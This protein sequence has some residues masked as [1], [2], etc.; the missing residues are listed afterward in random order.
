MSSL[1][2]ELWCEVLKNTYIYG[3]SIHNFSLSCRAFRAIALPHLFS[4][5]RFTPYDLRR[6][7]HI[8]IIRS[9][10][11]VERSMDRLGFWCSPAIAPLARVCHLRSGDFYDDGEST[12]DDPAFFQHLPLLIVLQELHLD[13][14]LLSQARVDAICRFSTGMLANLAISCCYLASGEPAAS[15]ELVLN[16]SA[17]RLEAPSDEFWPL[18][19]A[20]TPSSA[21]P[22]LCFRAGS[23][24]TGHST[25]PKRAYVGNLDRFICSP[26]KSA[27]LQQIYWAARSQ[28][29]A[30][31][32]NAS[33]ING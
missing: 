17:L 10:A 24:C 14:I 9:S 25:I 26:G 32:P 11:M 18:Q 6:V 15:L 21:F 19:V 13:S 7:E 28:T 8:P 16:V 12:T 20:P 29:C 33:P 1:P 5:F 27:I 4:T 2:S 22:N 3:D 23:R 30:G 31:P